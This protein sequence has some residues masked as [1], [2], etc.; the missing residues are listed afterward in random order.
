MLH[1]SLP[2]PF[3]SAQQE[4]KLLYSF[5][6]YIYCCQRR[7]NIKSIVALLSIIIFHIDVCM[8][9]LLDLCMVKNR[10]E[11]FRS[12]ITYIY[13]EENG[14]PYSSTSS[15]LFN[16]DSEEEVPRYKSHLGLLV[17]LSLLYTSCWKSHLRCLFFSYSIDP[18]IMYVDVRVREIKNFFLLQHEMSSVGNW[19]QTWLFYILYSPSLNWCF[20]F[21]CIW[22]IVMKD[23]ERG[24][25]ELRAKKSLN[26]EKKK[27]YKFDIVAVSCSGISSEKWVIVFP[28]LKVNQLIPTMWHIWSGSLRLLS[29]KCNPRGRSGIRATEEAS[30]PSAGSPPF[31]H[32]CHPDCNFIWLCITLRDTNLEMHYIPFVGEG[33]NPFVSLCLLWWRSA[34]V[35]ITVN[36]INEFG[37]TFNQPSY[38]VDVDEGRPADK[39]LQVE[40]TDGDCSAKYGDICRYELLNKDQPFSI[41]NEGY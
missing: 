3:C 27:N 15:S 30:S 32:D 18:F 20:I 40:A 34:T 9:M 1:K 26:C 33:F 38:V 36:D 29:C 22:Q 6:S 25:A 16:I 41:D 11:T 17:Q 4:E 2:T 28:F 23:R 12:P 31:S 19:L 37:P 13:I 8:C 39:I 7:K 24:E 5:P 14:S 10:K 21:H 35:H